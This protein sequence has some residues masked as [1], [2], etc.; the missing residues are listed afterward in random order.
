MAT[1]NDIAKAFVDENPTRWLWILIA[2]AGIVF[3][4]V[5]NEKVTY[6]GIIV[7]SYGLFAVSFNLLYGYM[8]EVPFGHAAF[9]GIGAYSA[10]I[11]VSQ[12][13]L[14]F[15]VAVLLSLLIPLVIGVVF[16]IFGAR[17]TAIYFA[18]F[19]LA[20]GEAV[21]GVLLTWQDMTGG[22]EGLY[23]TVPPYLESPTAYF[24]FAF[25]L[26]VVCL[27]VIRRVA[28]S[29]FGIILRTIRDNP[30]RIRSLGINTK[31]FQVINM[32]IAAAFAGVA[33][34]T[35]GPAVGI[36]YPNLA[37]WQT[38]A[39]A[40]WSSLVGGA[41]VFLGPVLGSIMY[42]TMR[43]QVMKITRHWPVLEGLFLLLVVLFVTDGVGGWVATKFSEF[44][45]RVRGVD[46]GTVTETGVPGED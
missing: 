44:R 27:L 40:L 33:G 32:T 24:Y 43:T 17:L 3:P 2:L 4:F 34:S 28:N 46:E 38:T 39:I 18:I 1:V 42:E 5:A 30:R 23:Y 11:A 21:R 20:F 15:P 22:T 25:V 36:L 26:T 35:F 14:P 13:G 7:L 9:Y 12:F 19:S 10:G 16:G 45:D 6:D 29:P 31:K 8:G 41:G 37:G